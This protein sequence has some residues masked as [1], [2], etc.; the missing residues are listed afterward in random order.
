MNLKQKLNEKKDSVFLQEVKTRLA[1]AYSD[2]KNVLFFENTDDIE[3]YRIWISRIRTDMKYQPFPMKGKDKCLK[4]YE[5]FKTQPAYKK[6]YFFI[7]HDFDG[8]KNYEIRDNLFITDR[9]SIENYLFDP[10]IIVDYLRAEFKCYEPN[11]SQ[12][13]NDLQ[14]LYNRNLMAFL[15]LLKNLNYQIFL[16]RSIGVD[17]KISDCKK[18]KESIIIEIETCSL[19]ESENLANMLDEDVYEL[20]K[21]KIDSEKMSLYEHR[22]NELQSI[23]SYR[24]KFIHF[25]FKEW[26]SKLKEYHNSTTGSIKYFSSSKAKF[27]PNNIDLYKYANYS[28]IPIGLGEFLE[29]IA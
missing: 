7:D 4:V 19:K 27:D 10:E 12:L 18:I 14:K 11:N 24:G 6:S 3:T 17:V 5:Y 21:E 1:G 9:Y 16:A 8:A 2:S 20:C 13:L 15:N 22:F 26:L 29:Q 28:P 25:F 23:N